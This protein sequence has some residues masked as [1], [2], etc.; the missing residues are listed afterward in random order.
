MRKPAIILVSF[1]T[2]LIFL[3][4]SASQ[5]NGDANAIIRFAHFS[6]DA[7]AVDIYINSDITRIQNLSFSD[8]TDWFVLPADTYAIH[9]VP[10][11]DALENAQVVVENFAIHDQWVTIALIG[12]RER[13]TLKLHPFFEDYH[14]TA[15]GEVRLSIALAIETA[16]PV[17]ILANGDAL[18][19]FVN[20]PDTSISPVTESNDGLVSVDIVANVYSIQVALNEDQQT[21]L[22]DLDDIDLRDGYNYLIAPIG[23]QGNP[24]FTMSRTSI[25]DL[26]SAPRD[27]LLT[28]DAP[29]NRTAR[30]RTAHLSSGTPRVDIYINGGLS[31]I[32]GLEF[33]SVSN[34]VELPSGQAEI[35]I[36]PANLALGDAFISSIMIQLEPDS[37]ATL[38]LIGTLANNSLTTQ[39][40]VEDFSEPAADHARISVFQGIPGVAPL[41]VNL[42]NRRE[43]IRLLGYPG[44]QGRNDGYESIE[45]AAGEYDL[46]I[47]GS[48][49][50]DSIV[51][52]IP[53]QIFEA[54][55]HYFIAT[56]RAD[57]P[58]IIVPTEIINNG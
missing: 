57:P 35:A 17:D 2:S 33:A 48:V 24:T 25:D 56:I 16:P 28:P 52:D 58:Y 31:A 37:W 11:G 19:Q 27:D 18:F 34:F 3:F 15:R 22:L 1:V 43:L 47:V 36:V 50:P 21:I 5:D 26:D 6:P 38:A 40:L 23:T 51:V 45:L 54:G 49:D 12:S 41:N 30:L 29:E 44:S 8:I 42:A 32:H 14:E 7:S 39:L 20:Y 53:P 13:D 55:R 10:A 4:A 9:I 46:E